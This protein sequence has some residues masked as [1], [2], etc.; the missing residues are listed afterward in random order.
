[1]TIIT[2]I[3]KLDEVFINFND[4][5]DSD[6]AITRIERVAD[7]DSVHALIMPFTQGISLFIEDIIDNELT[8]DEYKTFLTTA[9]NKEFGTEINK[10]EFL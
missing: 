4:E 10:I 8:L 1:M 6:S 5:Y 7:H 9:L 2:D 3:N